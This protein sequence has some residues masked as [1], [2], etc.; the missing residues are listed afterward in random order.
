MVVLIVQRLLVQ[1]RQ[2][3]QQPVDVLHRCV[4]VVLRKPAPSVAEARRREPAHRGVIVVQGHAELPGVAEALGPPRSLPGGL[5]RRQ[6][7][8]NQDADDRDDHQ[9]FDERKPLSRRV[10]ALRLIDES[11]WVTP[12]WAEHRLR[13]GKRGRKSPGKASHNPRLLTDVPPPPAKSTDR[14]ARPSPN[15]A[16]GAGR[17]HVQSLPPPWYPYILP[18][19]AHRQWL[20]SSAELAFCVARRHG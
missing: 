9:Q 3:Q 7:Q 15:P 2:H 19:P 17:G 12:R 16:R 10:R 1:V 4:G 8:R 5:D 20:I 13:R 11:P 6:Q 14:T 18:T